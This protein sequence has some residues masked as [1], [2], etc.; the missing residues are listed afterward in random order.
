MRH[1]VSTLARLALFA[2][3]ATAGFYLEANPH[4]VRQ[5]PPSAGL[6]VLELVAPPRAAWSATAPL[7][8][9]VALVR[10]ACGLAVGF[11]RQNTKLDAVVAGLAT[12]TRRLDTAEDQSKAA[13]KA[14][15]DELAQI[16][17]KL[18]RRDVATRPA[19]EGL[20]AGLLHGALI[21]QRPPQVM[22]RIGKLKEQAKARRQALASEGRPVGHRAVGR[23]E[24]EEDADF[25]V[26]EVLK[27]E[28]PK[29]K[30]ASKVAKR[31][32]PPPAQLPAPE[33]AAP[34]EAPAPP[35]YPATP[36]SDPA[37]RAVRIFEAAHQIATRNLPIL[38]AAYAA[39]ALD[40]PLR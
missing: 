26:P 9:A 19:P 17:I 22:E 27:P 8:P 38:D 15:L 32:A 33:L 25:E 35:E 29:R 18:D 4:L 6:V 36:V 39:G 13:Q 23:V 20:D 34:A 16:R 21:V 12:L 11:E 1:V 14:L 37:E 3:I 7:S 30:K 5:P 28:P 10:A 2:T 40:Q 24:L 31:S